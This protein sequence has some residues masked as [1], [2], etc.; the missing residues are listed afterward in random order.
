MVA[1]FS[2]EELAG[3]DELLARGHANGIEGLRIVGAEEALA[4]ESALSPEVRGALVAETGAICDPYG[5]TYGAAENAAANGA[6]FL[7]DE[8]VVAI[9]RIDGRAM[10]EGI[11]G[12]AVAGSG[13][14][15][16]AGPDSGLASA[17]LD[18]SAPRWR[19]R[20]ASGLVV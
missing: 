18:A 12:C 16:D 14:D 11:G 4:M 7:F 9:E 15:A 20:I 1:A 17:S 19:I 5:I 10:S 2:D 13:A 6:E 3:L 8:R